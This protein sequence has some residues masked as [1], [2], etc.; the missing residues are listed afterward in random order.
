M[1]L[2]TK[3]PCYKLKIGYRLEGRCRNLALVV[4]NASAQIAL[5]LKIMK[6][7]RPEKKLECL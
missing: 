7:G 1:S 3:L 2:R 5:S 6:K 4:F